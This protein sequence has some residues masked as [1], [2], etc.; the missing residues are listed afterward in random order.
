MWRAGGWFVC[1]SLAYLL[2]V[3][4]AWCGVVVELLT[5]GA[6]FLSVN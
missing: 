5:G 2:L 3:L 1:L 6:A 4:L